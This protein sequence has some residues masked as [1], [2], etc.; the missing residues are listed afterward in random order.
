MKNRECRALRRQRRVF[1]EAAL[2]GEE[3]VPGGIGPVRRGA[4]EVG[5]VVE[6]LVLRIHYVHTYTSIGVSED[7]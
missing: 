1:E 7:K 3:A 4:A 6:G 5:V 2:G